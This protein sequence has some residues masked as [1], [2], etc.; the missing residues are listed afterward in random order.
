MHGNTLIYALY[1]DE[2]G[3]WPKRVR[4][5]HA[6]RDGAPIMRCGVKGCDN[7]AVVKDHLAP[8]HTEYNSCR[9]HVGDTTSERP[10]W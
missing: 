8:S 2:G 3:M 9:Q 1:E 7:Y 10:C 6:I 5:S 4:L